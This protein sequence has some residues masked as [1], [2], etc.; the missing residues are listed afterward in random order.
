M[1]VQEPEKQYSQEPIEPDDA[2]VNP[3]DEPV[4]TEFT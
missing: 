2:Y 3:P 4:L 1:D